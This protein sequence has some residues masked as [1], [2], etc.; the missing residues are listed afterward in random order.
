M[1]ATAREMA[2]G[3]FGTLAPSSRATAFC[4]GAPFWRCDHVDRYSMGASVLENRCGTEWFVK[5][6]IL[7]FNRLAIVSHVTKRV[8]SVDRRAMRTVSLRAEA[9]WGAGS[10][11]EI[12]HDGEKI[13]VVATT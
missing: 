3:V 7:E 8:S 13:S 2:A 10:R 4:H 1:A 12:G 5:R 11:S 6:M 9:E